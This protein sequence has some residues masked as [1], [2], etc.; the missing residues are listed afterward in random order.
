MKLLLTFTFRMIFN[1]FL[2]FSLKKLSSKRLKNFIAAT[3]SWTNVKILINDDTTNK[4]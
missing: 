3:K 4:L 1:G 2:Q